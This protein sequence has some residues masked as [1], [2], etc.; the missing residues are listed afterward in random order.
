MVKGIRSFQTNGQFDVNKYGDFVQ[1]LLPAM[2]LSEAQIEELAGDQLRL[3]RIKSLLAIGVQIPES[4]S[5]ENFEAAYGKM[6][7]TVVR[8]RNEDFAK[9]IQINDSDV[10]KYYEA[11]KAELKSEEKRKV[12]FVSFAFTDEQKKLKGKERIEPLQKLADRANDFTQ[13]LLEKGADF[14]KTAAKFNVPVR[15]TGEFTVAVPDPQLAANQQLAQSAFQLT[16]QE[17]NSDAIQTAD[18]FYVLHLAAIDEARPLSLE[19]AKPKIVETLHKDRLNA[20]LSTK[21]AEVSQ[22]ILEKMKSGATAEAA[23][24]EAGLT[25]EKLPPF[26]LADDPLPQP[27]PKPSPESKLPPDLPMIK[28]S[29][30]Q[31]HPGEVSPF[32][33]S[34]DG[35]LIAV[36]EKREPLDA[37]RFEQTRPLLEDRLLQNKRAIVF[38]EWLTER[39]RDAGLVQEKA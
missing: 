26:S 30:A 31:L 4:E 14:Q 33:P 37:A 17:P 11:H 36:L 10:A 16:K 19:E 2:G 8:F 35:G 21:A 7:V 5:K 39:R 9:N 38:F 29:V 28:Q 6:D 23:I 20:S 25:A 1:N 32:I 22:Q 3:D 15:T 18:G 24:Q 34:A 12:D 13:A 27:K